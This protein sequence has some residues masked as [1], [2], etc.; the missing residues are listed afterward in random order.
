MSNSNDIYL[1]KILEDVYYVNDYLKKN[2]CPYVIG[3]S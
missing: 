1:F 3:I 2:F